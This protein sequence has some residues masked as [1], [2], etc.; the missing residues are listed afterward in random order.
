MLNVKTNYIQYVFK[1]GYLK[2]KPVLFVENLGPT[3]Y[4]KIIMNIYNYD[5]FIS[6]CTINDKTI[7]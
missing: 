5:F 6:Q 4:K 3:L 2:I 1:S 7:K